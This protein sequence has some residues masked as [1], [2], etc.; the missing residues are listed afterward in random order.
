MA[1][2]IVDVIVTGASN[3]AAGLLGGEL[4]PT[5]DIAADIA[6]VRA[7]PDGKER[8]ATELKRLL[9][10]N[11]HRIITEAKEALAI[12]QGWAHDS[13]NCDCWDLAIRAF[14]AAATT[15]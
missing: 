2:S 3:A 10:E 8:L 15:Q 7:M 6:T 9:R 13:L 1:E 5:A 12:S 14:H 4:T 11:I